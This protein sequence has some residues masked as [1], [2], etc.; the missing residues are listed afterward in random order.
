M[1]RIYVVRADGG[2]LRPL[3]AATGKDVVHGASEPAWSPDG[4]SIAFGRNTS[5]WTRSSIVVVELA[6]GAETEIAHVHDDVVYE[7]DWQPRPKV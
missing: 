6:S 2:G 5:G 3:T 4:R 1:L 7:P